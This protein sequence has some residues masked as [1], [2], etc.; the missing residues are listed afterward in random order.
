MPNLRA[1]AYCTCLLASFIAVLLFWATDTSV[2][3]VPLVAFA[4]GVVILAGLHVIYTRWRPDPIVG[5][6][7]GGLVV[8]IWAALVAAMAALAAL[9]TGAPLID[10]SLAQ[11]DAIFG[12]YTPTLV[13]WVASYSMITSVLAVA[14][15][16]TVPMVFATVILLGLKRREVPMWELCFVFAATA[17]LCAFLSAVAPAIAAFTYYG[18]PSE[19]VMMLPTGAGR[20]F[21]PALEAYH[22]RTVSVVDVRHLEGVVTFPSFHAIMALMTA[23]ALRDLGALSGLAWMWSSIILISTIPIGGHYA[24]DIIGGAVVWAAITLLIR[25]RPSWPR[26][27]GD[28]VAGD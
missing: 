6:I 19:I 11:A 3:A 13:K 17:P 24:I 7:C 16:S 21:L 10:A 26:G 14:Y 12:L 8:V 22:S 9:R 18:I 15:V 23:Y 1:A 4:S 2:A 5:P 20:F 25:V 28:I 27:R